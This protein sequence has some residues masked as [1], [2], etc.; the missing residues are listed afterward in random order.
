MR[1]ERRREAQD[2]ERISAYLDDALSDEAQHHLEARLT[3]E[4]ELRK[5][6]EAL[7]ATKRLLRNLPPIKAPHNF[8][9]SPDMVSV[10]PKKKQPLFAALRWAS[11]LA[12]ILLVVLVGIDVF[13]ARNM[14]A[15]SPAEPK[16][17]MESADMAEVA[18]PEPLILWAPSRSEG[19]GGDAEVAGLGSSDGFMAEQTAGE[20]EIL[21]SEGV[22]EEEVEVPVENSEADE[23]MPASEPPQ[24][25]EPSRADEPESM[26]EEPMILSAEPE[27]EMLI[28]G[29][30]PEQGGEIVQRSQPLTFHVDTPASWVN[31]LRWLQIVMAAIAVFGGAMI[32]ILQRRN[33]S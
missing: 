28:L 25:I 3:N 6:L 10:Y 24:E 19:G 13:L 9:L 15:I 17:M 21:P 11:S 22:E 18:Q 27:G 33:S 4:P 32:W 26:V 1:D 20:A 8:T 29:I 12:A 5:Q 31:N 14:M 2:L 30:N 7:Q 23:E 16:V